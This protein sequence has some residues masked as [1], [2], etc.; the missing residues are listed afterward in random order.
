MKLPEKF[1]I[2]M[3]N[4]EF[5]DLIKF[6]QFSNFKGIRNNSYEINRHYLKGMRYFYNF[7]TK[8]MKFFN[9][10]NTGADG[11]YLLYYKEII[12]ELKL[13]VIFGED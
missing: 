7:N 4:D 8:S 12:R 6:E 5:Q 1:S 9:T 3:S 11:H 2:V 13:N 10:G